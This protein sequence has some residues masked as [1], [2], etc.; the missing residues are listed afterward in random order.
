MIHDHIEYD[1]HE[2]VLF[3]RD[4]STGLRANIALHGTAAG[5][6]M[7]GCRVAPYRSEEDALTDVLRLSKAMSYK[8]IMAGLP[9]GGGKAVIIAHPRKDKTPALLSAFARHV[10]RLSGTFITGE[11]V[12]ISA[13]D[14]QIMRK[15]T[16]HVRGIPENGPGDPSPMTALGVVVGIEAAWSH[17]HGRD[18]VSGIRILI[19]GLGAVGM[20]LGALLNEAG[21]QLVVADIDDNRVQEAVRRFG[22]VAVNKETWADADVDV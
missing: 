22:A 18:D 7:G 15:T 11:G 2:L 4:L 17:K 6:A 19:Q 1:D 14:V 21:A 9:Y 13:A 16:A 20:R 12:G 8:N 5:P 3:C 10:E